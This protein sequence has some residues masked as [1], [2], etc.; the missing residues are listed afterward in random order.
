MRPAG[1]LGDCFAVTV[2]HPVYSVAGVIMFVEET[3]S[4]YGHVPLLVRQAT[5]LQRTSRRVSSPRSARPP[6]RA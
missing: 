5:E 1:N 6:R 4:I 3:G 2:A